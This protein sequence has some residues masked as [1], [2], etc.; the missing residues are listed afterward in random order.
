MKKY[1]FLL[2]IVMALPLSGYSQSKEALRKEFPNKYVG[3]KSG[4]EGGRFIVINDF[5]RKSSQ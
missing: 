2:G 1:L 4:R 5:N 3:I